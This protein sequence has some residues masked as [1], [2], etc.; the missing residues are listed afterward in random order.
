[1]VILKVDGTGA[2]A[3]E[4]VE[5]RCLSGCDAVVKR[6]RETSRTMKRMKNP[7]KIS[8]PW[9]TKMRNCFIP[10]LDG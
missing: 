5:S 2:T 1:M 10:C 9:E 8:N 3:P 6:K 7:W 4:L